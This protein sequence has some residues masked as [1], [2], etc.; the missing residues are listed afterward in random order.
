MEIKKESALKFFQQSAWVGI[1]SAAGG[2]LMALAHKYAK[3]LGPDDY[4]VYA[5]LLQAWTLMAIPSQGLTAVFMQFAA[6]A[7][8]LGHRSVLAGAVRSVFKLNLVVWSVF[9]LVFFLF[10]HKLESVLGIS[11]AAFLFVTAL[12]PPAS[13][14]L[15]ASAFGYSEQRRVASRPGCCLDSWQL[16]RWRVGKLGLFGLLKAR[17]FIGPG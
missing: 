6:S 12:V 8:A 15:S 11:S 2:G 5:V 3:A 1:A 10:R 16:W 9:G 17:R 13:A 4:G 7:E 14:F